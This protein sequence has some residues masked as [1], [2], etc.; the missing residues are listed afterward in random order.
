M[1]IFASE[2]AATAAFK[3]R[4]PE[5]TVDCI[6]QVEVRNQLTKDRGIIDLLSWIRI[7]TSKG[8]ASLLLA[9]EFKRGLIQ[10][11]DYRRAVPQLV[12]YIRESTWAD[13][14]IEMIGNVRDYVDYAFVFPC[15]CKYDIEYGGQ[16]CANSIPAQFDRLI[17]AFGIG[18]AAFNHHFLAMCGDTLLTPKNGWNDKALNHRKWLRSGSAS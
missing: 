18:T 6:E 14:R 7:E 10:S 16:S 15:F 4:Y 17:G 13:P 11:A 8:S 3:K 5:L 1:D 9:F 2:L 12:S